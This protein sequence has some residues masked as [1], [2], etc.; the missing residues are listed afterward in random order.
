MALNAHLSEKSHQKG[1]RT[2]F[3]LWPL[4]SREIRKRRRADRG[5]ATAGIVVGS[6]D[7]RSRRDQK[8][9]EAAA[10]LESIVYLQGLANIAPAPQHS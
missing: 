3:G 6:G 1:D 2:E 7:C 4:F 8:K 10:A 9:S 5:G